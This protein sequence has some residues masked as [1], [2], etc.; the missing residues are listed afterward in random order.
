MVIHWQGLFELHLGV[1][2][3]EPIK[4]VTICPGQSDPLYSPMEEVLSAVRILAYDTCH[5]CPSTGPL[6]S[7]LRTAEVTNR[8]FQL[9]T[10]ILPK[11]LSSRLW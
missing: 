8:L 10:N 3:K 5:E 1:G 6:R 2:M 11:T 9:P 4:R 7:F